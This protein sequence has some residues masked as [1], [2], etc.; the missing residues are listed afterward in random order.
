MKSM[1]EALIESARQQIQGAQ[2]VLVVSHIHPDGDAVGS[3]LGLGSSLQTAGKSVQM[4]LTDGIPKTFRYLP[5]YDQVKKHPDGAFDLSIVLDCSDLQRTGNALNG[6]TPPDWN[7]D[8]HPTNLNFA[9]FNWV[10]EAATA[11]SEILASLLPA[12]GLPIDSSVAACFLTGLV[13]DTLGFRTHNVTPKV[14]HLAAELMEGGADLPDIYQRVLFSRSYEAAR[15]WGKG[16]NNLQKDGRMVWTT[17]TL[18]DR[19]AVGYPGR[20]DADLIN[21]LSSLDEFDVGLIFIEETRGLV[22]VSWRSRP[23]YNVAQIAMQYGGG[24]HYA[25]AGAEIEGNLGDVQVRVLE[26]TRHL[27]DE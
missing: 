17:L 2:R 21:V 5:G 9:R 10:N 1:N 25:A 20:D 23:G 26:A 4:V 27:F 13:A 6:N 18:T 7:I 19:Q 14:L 12:L 22:K 3:L 11:T 15:Y 24:G 8:H 16:L